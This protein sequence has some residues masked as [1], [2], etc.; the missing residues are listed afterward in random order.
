MNTRTYVNHFFTVR[1]A[2]WA[3][4]KNDANFVLGPNIIEHKYVK[5]I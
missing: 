4:L 5:Y 1:S 2:R 3:I